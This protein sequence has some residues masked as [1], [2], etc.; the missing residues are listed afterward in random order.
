M[1]TDAVFAKVFALF[2]EPMFSVVLDVL[3]NTFKQIL[4]LIFCNQ[5][6]STSVC[7]E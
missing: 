5:V 7:S 3:Y 6:F 2:A 4:L 1:Y